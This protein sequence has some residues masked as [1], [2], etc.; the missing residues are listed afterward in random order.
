[1]KLLRNKSLLV[2]LLLISGFGYIVSC[3]RDNDL[4][5]PV[6]LTPPFVATRGNN[7]H[8]PGNMTAGD[9]TQWKLDKVHSSTLWSTAYVGAAGL[10]TGRFNQFGMHDVTDAEAI[11]YNTTGQPLLDNSWAFYESD[12]TKTFFNGYVQINTSNTGEPGRDAGC[13]ISG[14]G[15]VPIVAGTQNLAYPN[16][17]KIKTTKIELDPASN[18]YIVTFDLTYQGKLSAPLTKSIIGTL[19]YIK[20]QTVQFGTA[21]A[22]DVFGLQL[23]FQFNCRDYGIVSTSI[24]DVIDIECNMNFNNK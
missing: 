15:T 17:A 14:M 7:V 1:M 3:T 8:L 6:Q 20:R 24:G 4:L 11:S 22:Y 16:L 12:P 2:L 13:N 21:A 10:L 9:T 18:G 23:K 5:V 19:K